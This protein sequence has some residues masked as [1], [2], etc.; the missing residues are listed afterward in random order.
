MLRILFLSFYFEPDLCAGSFRNTALLKAL[1]PKLPKDSHVDVITTLPSRYSS[2]SVNA[3]AVEKLD[4]VRIHRI[5]LPKH[6][7]GMIDQSI[8]FL[9]YAYAVNKLIKSENYDL[10][11]ASSS[12]LMTAF[13]AASISRNKQAP[14]YL[15]IRDIF[16][17]TI[18][19]VL[20][21]KLSWFFKPFFNCIE[22]WAFSKANT[23]NLVSQG[24]EQYFRERYPHI[25][26]TFFTNGIDKE[27]VSFSN[28]SKNIAKSNLP[29]VIYA[30]NLGEGQGLHNIIPSL[31]KKFEGKLNFKII[32]D[33]GRKAQLEEALK[34]SEVTNVRLIPPVE[35][36]EL[37]RVYEESDILFM[38][39]NDYDAF[40]KVLPSKVF[41]YAA[42]G[43]PIWAGVSGYSARF[44]DEYV[45]NAVVFKPC[46]VFDAANKFS[47]LNLDMCNRA[48]FIK[49][50]SRDKIM[51][52]M[53]LSILETR[54]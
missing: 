21:G 30:G 51:Q 12:R 1:I 31:A 24:F 22:K 42:L 17:D 10:I 23:I 46:D 39:L 19:D 33:G 8:A 6:K 26:L 45:T 5:A 34:L 4:C 14:L 40:L 50:F 18:K 25:P 47:Q 35:R 49:E 52:E 37:I 16:V 38:H 2:F 7:S 15:D 54:N 29:E 20:P 3:K 36:R 9:S 32:G 11:Y 48:E 53:A 13:L 27:F 41:E 43:K 44:I 28:S